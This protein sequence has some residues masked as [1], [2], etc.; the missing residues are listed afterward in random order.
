MYV[1]H[2][3]FEVDDYRK[4]LKTS[5]GRCFVINNDANHHD[6]V[7][8]TCKNVFSGQFSFSDMHKSSA[9][10]SRLLFYILMKQ[11][12]YTCISNILIN[13]NNTPPKFRA[14]EFLSVIW[15]LALL[16]F[17]ITWRWI[18]ERYP[19]NQKSHSVVCSAHG[20]STY[21]M[22][23]VQFSFS[24]FFWSLKPSKHL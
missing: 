8:G 10:V 19:L 1:G 9:R 2:R 5:I 22:A 12:T 18:E 16:L 21:S 3:T 24:L 23:E 20:V 14:V 17:D 6:R 7:D 11:L 13:I 15:F 4:D